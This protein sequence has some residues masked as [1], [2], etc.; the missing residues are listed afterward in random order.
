MTFGNPT[1]EFAGNV[2]FNSGAS[3]V[4]FTMAANSLDVGGTLS[5]SGGAGTTTLNTSGSNLAINAVTLVVNAG[6]A[7]TANGSTITATS[8]DN[9]LRTFT[10]GRSNVGVNL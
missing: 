9:P 10:D 4:T 7:L 8:M 2:T 6:G 3:T 1:L 5:I